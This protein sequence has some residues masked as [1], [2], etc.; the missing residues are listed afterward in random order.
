MGVT[1]TIVG[2]AI[3]LQGQFSNKDI[4]GHYRKS[5]Q[6]DR[7]YYE[8]RIWNYSILYPSSFAL[9]E[10]NS[11]D[12]HYIRVRTSLSDNPQRWSIDIIVIENS[13]NEALAEWVRGQIGLTQ[14]RSIVVNELNGIK[15]RAYGNAFFY[16]IYFSGKGVVYQIEYVDPEE[17]VEHMAI[18]EEIIRS[19][20]IDQ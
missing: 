13:D 16:E 5:M 7:L 12:T 18:Y 2:L 11:I 15:A 6:R 3:V 1:I 19:F 17:N 9:V 4:F 20:K 8:N 14:V 10:D